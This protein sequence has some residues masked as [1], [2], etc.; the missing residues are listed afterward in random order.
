MKPVNKAQE[1]RGNYMTKS[2]F[3]KNLKEQVLKVVAINIEV[4]LW[5]NEESV[6]LVFIADQDKTFPFVIWLDASYE[7]SK[8]CEDN[9]TRSIEEIENELEAISNK[10]VEI[11]NSSPKLTY[12]VIEETL[13]MMS[14]LNVPEDPSQTKFINYMKQYCEKADQKKSDYEAST[15]CEE[16]QE[17]EIELD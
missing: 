6:A 3:A 9:K 12:R 2:E 15:D 14:K 17:D 13:D 1:R 16:E 10:I 5:Q 8:L 7:E 4:E 11:Y